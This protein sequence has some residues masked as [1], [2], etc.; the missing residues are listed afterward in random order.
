M[1][2]SYYQQIGNKLAVVDLWNDCIEPG[3]ASMITRVNVPAEYRRQGIATRL[4]NQ[5]LS[6]ADKD[7]VTLVLEINPYG[8]M[9][10]NQLA[11]WYTRLGF[12]ETDG[13]VFIREPRK[14]FC[15]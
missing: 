9:S 12:V 6:D 11:S 15:D 10:W 4:M 1:K 14:D 2:S 13:K 7:G 8:E 5:V 3:P